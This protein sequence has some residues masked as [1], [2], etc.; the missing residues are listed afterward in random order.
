MFGYRFLR[1]AAVALVLY[2]ILGLLTAMAM[3]VVGATTFSQIATLQHALETEREALV[4]SL[5]TVSSTLGNTAA[6]TTEFERSI[7]AARQAADGASKLANDSAG[8]FR[9]LAVRMNLEVFGF[10]P[11]AT[12]APQFNNSAD[13]LTQLAISLGSTRDALGQNGDDVQRIGGN[14]QQLQG[15]VD[16]VATSLSQPGV[17]GFG[18]QALLP[19]QIAVYGMCLLVLL[20]SA[21]S[22]VAGVALY[23]L[24]RAMGEQPLFPFLAQPALPEPRTATTS[25]ADARGHAPTSTPAQ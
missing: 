23:R 24:Q 8:T 10:Q 11:L 7:E 4:A 6:A 1:S 20:Q 3:L 18:S 19:F 21:F 9:D 13:Q 17:L 16:A 15:Q 2:G 25:V 14:L 22:I 5:R 12:I